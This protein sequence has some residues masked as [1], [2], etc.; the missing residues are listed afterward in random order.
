MKNTSKQFGPFSD[1]ENKKITKYKDLINFLLKRY[2][3]GS[4]KRT[5][6]SI[7]DRIL[8]SEHTY[9]KWKDEGCPSFEKILPED[10]KKKLVSGEPLI[11]RELEYTAENIRSIKSW[12]ESDLEY[13]HMESLDKE[14][15]LISEKAIEPAMSKYLMGILDG[16]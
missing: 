9:M 11:Q 15:L 4:L 7:S 14:N 2:K 6:D 1:T 5:L 3:V 10:T 16:S 12:M 8:S 13:S